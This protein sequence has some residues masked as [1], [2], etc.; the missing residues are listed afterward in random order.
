[1][2]AP[3]PTEPLCRALIQMEARYQLFPRLPNE[4]ARIVVVGVSGG[5]DSVCLLHLLLHFAPSWHLALHVA[6]LDH[7]VRPASAQDA[8][9]VRE[10]AAGWGL[11]FHTRRLSPAEIEAADNN[12]EAGLRRLRYG[13]FADVAASLAGSAPVAPTVAVAH[14]ADDQAETILMHVLRGSGLPGLV[15]MQPI[16]FLPV[17]VGENDKIRIVR[18]L[19]DVQH[20]HILHYLNTHALAW[21]ED[22]TNQ[23]LT[24]TRNRLRH[25]I[26]PRLA[27]IYPNL[28]GA[29]S[30]LGALLAAEN[31]RAERLNEAAFCSLLADFAPQPTAAPVRAVLDRVALRG[32]D[33]ATQRGVLRC[34][35]FYLGLPAD[36]MDYERTES[37]RVMLIGDETGGPTPLAAEIVWSAEPER[38]SL[39]RKSALAF[40]LQQ[41]FLDEQ[42]RAIYA[43]ESLA[44]Q[45]PH[46]NPPQIGEGIVTTPPPIWGRLGG[47]A[48]LPVNGE[49]AVGEWHL[50]CREME[51]ADLPANW[52]EKSDP[53][54]VYCDAHDVGELLLTTARRGQQFAPL[55]MGGRH[56]HLGDF[57]TDSKIA[58][59]LRAGWPLLL[60][61]S[62]GEILWV[63]G[64]RLAHRARI[65]AETERIFHLKW[66]KE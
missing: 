48:Q 3:D 51:R 6:H 58:V 54:Q 23:D 21:R 2:S 20:T 16:T 28:T 27:E 15:G 57:F 12:L 11:P 65:R 25:Q 1:M 31:E 43:V 37:L 13:F 47:G 32:L 26:L 41:P 60:D 49:I 55:G 62:S 45:P 46:P 61:G 35:V 38:F 29:L 7:N 5:A 53:W 14:N 63:C 50:A 39:H 36:E 40:P 10:L 66:S 59:A 33:V 42:W 64:L 19:L 18:P 22:A 52:Q 8:A 9:F 56:K 17:R 44:T 34:A 30:R 4:E 24:F